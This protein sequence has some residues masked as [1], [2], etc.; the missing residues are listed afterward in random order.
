MLIAGLLVLACGRGQEVEEFKAQWMRLTHTPVE[1]AKVGRSTQVRAEIEV[2]EDIGDVDLLIYYTA[3]SEPQ[4][5][6]E[7]DSLEAGKYF[8][9]IPPQAR[10]TLVEYH[11]EARAGQ[12]LAVRV[13]GDEK[14]PGFTYYY[15]GTPNR[16]L[17]LT[18]IVLMFFALLVFLFVGY[19]SIRALRNRQMI[20]AIPRLAFLGTIFFFISSIPLGMIV[21]YQTYGKPWTG[22]PVGNDLTDNK[23]LAILL[24]WAAAS[25][26]YRGSLFRRDPARDLLGVKSLP[27]V[28]LTG[29]VL[30]VVLYALPH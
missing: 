24:Y 28:Y 1:E 4:E 14:T 3:G 18:H 17:L 2:S 26:L 16:T 30:T 5:I 20:V 6:V 8:G 15:K 10:G 29:V 12:D 13:P 19:L 25:F 22:F 21:A 7:M 11:I 27:Y 9:A 23:S